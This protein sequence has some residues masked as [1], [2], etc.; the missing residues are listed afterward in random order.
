MLVSWGRQPW[1][2]RGSTKLNLEAASDDDVGELFIVFGRERLG[3]IISKRRE[4]TTD[5]SSQTRAGGN[6]KGRERD[7]VALQGRR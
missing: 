4:N 6:G 7:A 2:S 3:G 1:P 5:W